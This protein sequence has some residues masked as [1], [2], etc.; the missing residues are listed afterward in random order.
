MIDPSSSEDEDDDQRRGPG[1]GMPP[2]SMGPASHPPAAHGAHPAAAAAAAH[3]LALADE[4]G[5]GLRGSPARTSIVPGGHGAM[6]HGAAPHGH[7]H[8]GPGGSMSHGPAYGAS[9]LDVPQ[10]GGIPR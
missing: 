8:P 5:L 4:A 3:Q 7:G 9:A 2:R 6:V 1:D 10:A